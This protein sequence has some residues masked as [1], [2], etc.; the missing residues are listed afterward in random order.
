MNGSA[1]RPAATLILLGLLGAAP[2]ASAQEA[3][4]GRPECPAGVIVNVFV[5]NQSIYEEDG[6]EDGQSHGWVQ[7]LAA[8]VANRVHIR[9]RKGLIESELLF[10]AGDCF[11][12]LLLDESERSLRSLSFLAEADIRHA[13]ASDGRMDV[14]VTTRDDWTLKL[15]VRPELDQGLR[16]AYLGGAEENFLGTGTLLG[17]YVRDQVE[18]RDVGVHLRNP[19]LARTRFDG[20]ISGGRTRTGTFFTES[21]SYPFVGEVGRWAFVES[22]SLRED[23]FPYATQDA[24][25]S[26]YVSLPM[27][28]R[29]AEVTVGRRFGTPGNLTVL[30]AGVSWEGLRFDDFPEGVEVVPGLDY[31]SRVNADEA[32]IEAVAGQTAPRRI[33][34]LHAVVGKRNIRFITRRGLDAV[35]AEQDVRVGT[36]AMVAAGTTLGGAEL[37]AEGT[38]REVRGSISLFGGAAGDSWVFNSE[39]NLE[40]AWLPGTERPARS[41]RDVLGEF[42]AY[43]YW[44]PGVASRHT[45]V[46]GLSGAGGWDN[47]RPFQLTLG[48]PL[49]VR[50]YGRLDFPAARRLVVNLEDRITLDAPFSDVFDVGLA[51]FVD[52]GA[53]WKGDAPFSTDSGLRGAAGA[54]LRFAFPDGNRQV[55]RFDL[56]VPLEAGGLRDYQLRIG[57]DATSLLATLRDLQVLR[58][59][60]AGPSTVF[61]GG[62]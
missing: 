27:Q 26:T 8:W 19:R 28:T 29:R 24:G 12:Q 59:R 25:S 34:R 62:R 4:E 13:P 54:G 47:A 48:G 38:H 49:R 40:G 23:I 20:A 50:G 2:S 30:A 1:V 45:V 16:F 22:Y 60:G 9:T 37:G 33:P 43:L 55:V 18:Q 58:S 39:L 61:L 57:Y 21:L 41:F 10:R 53:G 11:D 14:F 46:L 44:Q 51:F 6:P 56:A 52:V 42:D 17:V 3:P 35:R 5:E 31:S 7:R 15:D 36:Q 32:M